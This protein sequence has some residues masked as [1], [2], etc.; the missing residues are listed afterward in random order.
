M[1][2]VGRI[3]R[4]AVWML[5]SAAV[6]TRGAHA[7]ASP[8]SS[9]VAKPDSAAVAKPDTAAAP[10][11]PAPATPAATTPAPAAAA[12]AAVT[13]TATPTA[14]APVKEA[15]M[16]SKGNKRVSGMVGWGH[17]FDTDYLLLGIGVGYF[18]ANGLDVGV[19]FEGWLVGDPTVYK[20]SPRADYVLWKAKR[21]KPYAGAF[22]RWNFVGGNIDDQSSLGGRVG[23]FYQSRG[24]RSM[25]G[26]GVVYE[27]YLN[28]DERFGSSDVVYPEVFV[29]VSF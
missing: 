21:I 14:A 8:D 12:P 20:L 23:A 9:G 22:Y 6:L 28:L 2:A 17:S 27:R 7:Q 16:F 1:R 29:A 13:A 4:I 15:G 10:A 24:G 3:I 11:T 19:D 18:L 25:A 5:V 26:A